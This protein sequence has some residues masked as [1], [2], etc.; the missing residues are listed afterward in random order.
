MDLFISNYGSANSLFTNDGNGN[1]W[2]NIKCDGS[3]SN[4]SGI[5]TKIWVKATIDGSPVWQYRQINMQSGYLAQ[6]SL[7]EEF[8]LGNAQIVDSIIIKWPSGLTETYTN[9]SVN[10][11]YSAK[12]N[13]GIVTAVEDFNG[14]G[15]TNLAS[16][17]LSQNY[18]N[19]FNPSTKI[20]YAIPAVISTEGR[21]LNVTLKIFDVLGN[22]IAT[23]VNEVKSVGSYEVNFDASK[24]SSGVYFYKLEAG[25]FVETKKMMLMK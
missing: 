12:E 8:G 17:N 11:F 6:N 7:N 1:S 22:E 20:R 15:T 19:P 3:G 23:L 4:A 16:F 13:Q 24:L 21:N 18:P 9:K 5:G 10:A 2:I 14:T 25:S